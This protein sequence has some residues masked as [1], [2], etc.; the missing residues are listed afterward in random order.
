MNQASR[1][2]WLVPVLPAAVQPGISAFRAV[3]LIN[4]SCIM[5]FMAATLRGSITWLG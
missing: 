4:V 1:K 3:P 5:V 2:S